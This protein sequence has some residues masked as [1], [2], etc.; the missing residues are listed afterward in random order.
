MEKRELSYTVGGNVYR[1][2]YCREQCGGSSK[3]TKI[4]YDPAIPLQG[5][6]PEKIKIQYVSTGV[7]V[8]AQQVKNL[9]SIF[10]NWSSIPGLNQRV[11][12]LALLKAAALHCRC[13]GV[14]MAVV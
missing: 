14:S 11:K 3:K 1:W 9:T 6:Y 8:V 7:P 13:Y 4:P 5:I 10:E 12:D 2:S